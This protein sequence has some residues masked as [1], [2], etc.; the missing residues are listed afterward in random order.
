MA[1]KQYR[2]DLAFTKHN[3]NSSDYMFITYLKYDRVCCIEDT[4]AG[5]FSVNKYD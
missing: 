5:I 4:E 3:Q 1:H 2:S